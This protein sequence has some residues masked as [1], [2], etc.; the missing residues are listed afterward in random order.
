MDTPKKNEKEMPHIKN[1]ED[2][3]Y[4]VESEKGELRKA[5]GRRVVARGWGWGNGKMLVKVYKLSVI[6]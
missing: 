4:N 5:E 6:R 1:M 2:L 3:A